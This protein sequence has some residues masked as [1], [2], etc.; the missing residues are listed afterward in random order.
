MST[1]LVMT[2]DESGQLTMWRV[3]RQRLAWRPRSVGRWIEGLDGPLFVLAV[4]PMTWYLLNW[5]AA[6]LATTIA[7]SWRAMT[8]RWPV[9]AYTLDAVGEDKFHRIVVEGCADADALARRWALDVKEHG[10]PRA[11][12][13]AA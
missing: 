11:P 3:G 7:W 6:L 1:V 5:L 2:K 8:G 12:V 4:I 9:V 10:Q 13:D